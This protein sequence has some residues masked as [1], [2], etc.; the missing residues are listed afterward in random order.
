[1][2]R[3]H[4]VALPFHRRFLHRPHGGPYYGIFHNGTAFNANGPANQSRHFF[5]DAIADMSAQRPPY[6]LRTAHHITFQRFPH[7]KV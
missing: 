5:P 4:G 2:T 1:M 7:Q 3:W 6:Y